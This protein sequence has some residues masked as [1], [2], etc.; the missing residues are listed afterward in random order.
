MAVGLANVLGGGRR[1]YDH[2][3]KHLWRKPRGKE[4]HGGGGGTEK[5]I[6][7]KGLKQQNSVLKAGR[8]S[9]EVSGE[10]ESGQTETIK[11]HVLKNQVG[12]QTKKGEM[13]EGVGKRFYWGER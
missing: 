3:N 11:N 12:S 6:I 5:R 13:R 8:K 2:R 4:V 9:R 10:G 1:E 7:K